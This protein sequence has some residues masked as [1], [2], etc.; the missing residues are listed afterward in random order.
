MT[1]FQTP[2]TKQYLIPNSQF[3]KRILS[4]KTDISMFN[5]EKFIFRICL[6]FGV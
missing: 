5:F 1:K 6:E 4:S 2:N 3:S